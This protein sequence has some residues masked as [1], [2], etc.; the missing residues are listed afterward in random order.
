MLK[1]RN[2]QL[3][4]KFTLQENVYTHEFEWLEFS[5]LKNE[6]FYPLFL[7][8]EIYNLPNEFTIITEIE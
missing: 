8:E 4:D 5:R 2:Y 6:Y 7:K 3:G 1:I